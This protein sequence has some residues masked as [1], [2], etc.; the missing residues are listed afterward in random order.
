M[1]VQKVSTEKKKAWDYCSKY[2][3]LHYAD[4]NGF[5]ACYTCGTIKF[6]KEMQAGHG[7]GGRGSSILFEEKILR[8]QCYSCNVRKYGNTDIFHAKLIKEYGPKF[9]D[10][11]LKQKNIL[12]QFSLKEITEIHDKY[13]KLYEEELSKKDLL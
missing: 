10:K 11:M 13:K 4:R 6:W 5:V 2:I 8:P 7:I 12:K 9:L 3:R 1:K